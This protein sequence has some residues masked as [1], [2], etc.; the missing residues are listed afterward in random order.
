MTSHSS[1]LS[2]CFEGREDTLDERVRLAHKPGEQFDLVRVY[3]SP[4][5]LVLGGLALLPE[6]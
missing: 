3:L 4:A 1:D 5:Q 6:P 2:F